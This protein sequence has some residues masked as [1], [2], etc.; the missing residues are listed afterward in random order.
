MQTTKFHESH[1]E[2]SRMRNR[3]K[4]TIALVFLNNVYYAE[5]KEWDNLNK[6]PAIVEKRV[7][8]ND[9][10]CKYFYNSVR[11]SQIFTLPKARLVIQHECLKRTQSNDF[12]VYYFGKMKCNT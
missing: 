12:L 8:E 7:V 6:Q 9:Q 3:R 4:N 5:T 1:D 11:L 2:N 10:C